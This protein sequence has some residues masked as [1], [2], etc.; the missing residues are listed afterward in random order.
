[1]GGR[2]AA[3]IDGASLRDSYPFISTTKI[4]EARAEADRV[5]TYLEKHVFPIYGIIPQSV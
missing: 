4:A 2:A 1:M 3:A 5:M